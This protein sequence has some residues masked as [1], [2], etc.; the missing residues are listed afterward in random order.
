MRRTLTDAN[1]LY[2]SVLRN[3]LMHLATAGVCELRWSDDIHEEWIRN[4][5]ARS[6]LDEDRPRRTRLQMEAAL[7][8]ARVTDYEALI[9]RLS[10]PDPDDRHVL[11]A[12]IQGEAAEILTFNLRD[13]PPDLTG[14]H[15]VSPTHPDTWLCRLCGE[16]PEMVAAST[17]RML[18]S[19]KNPPM[20]PALL[21][22][23]LSRLNL[24][25]AAERIA[26]L[27][28]PKDTHD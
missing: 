4:L 21:A 22:S 24:P 6:G 28:T 2:P 8:E 25:G 20:T 11:A 27:L 1:V 23:A 14:P 3:L 9:P 10:L 13:F 26:A 15:G 19:L 16:Q 17:R 7:P 18:R 5:V 12:A